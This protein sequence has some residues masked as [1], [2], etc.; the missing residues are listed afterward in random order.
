MR[1][2]VITG[3]STGIGYDAARAL[4]A[5][6]YHVFGSVRRAEDGERVR[7]EMGDGFTPLLFDVTDEAAVHAAAAMVAD[8]VGDAGLAGLVNNAGMAVSGPAQH[9]ALDAFRRQF[10]VNHPVSVPYS[11]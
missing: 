9:V 10:E 3:V 2:V 8:Q 6:G 11:Q 1:A 7:S 4:V 5:R